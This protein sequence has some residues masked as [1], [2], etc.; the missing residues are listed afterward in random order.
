MDGR[1]EWYVASLS[2]ITRYQA[3]RSKQAGL[4][5]LGV[6]FCAAGGD[7]RLG[8]GGGERRDETGRRMLDFK[9]VAGSSHARE[10]DDVI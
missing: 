10:A 7:R 3:L 5:L 9:R 4:A 6:R 2:R 8:W 1:H